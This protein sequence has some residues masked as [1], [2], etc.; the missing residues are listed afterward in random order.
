MKH[1]RGFIL[2]FGLMCI[3]FLPFTTWAQTNDTLYIK[4][5]QKIAKGQE[6]KIN[7]G[8]Q[9]S[10]AS[11]AALWVEG[12]L[13]VTGDSKAPVI[14]T[15]ENPEEPG[16]GIIING[17]DPNARI[18]IHNA[19]FNSLLRPLSFEPFWN[20]KT[21]SLENLNVKNS[22]FNEA[23]IFVAAPLVNLNKAAIQFELSN[24][25]FFHNNAGII[26]E[27]AGSSGIV[28]NLDNLVFQ[29]NKLVG[30]DNSLGIL[31]INIAN[32]YNPKNLNIG[33]LVFINNTANNKTLGLSL[34]GSQEAI[35]AEGI[36]S[37]NN[38]RPVFD[39]QQDARLPLLEA[40][41]KD[42]S[43]YPLPLCYTEN[44]NH[45]KGRIALI[46]KK[47]CKI[48]KVVD[49]NYVTIPATYSVLA[50]SILINY[51]EGVAAYVLL[52]NGMEEKLPAIPL[53]DTTSLTP[54]KP[55]PPIVLQDT[56]INP[57][58]PWEKTYE[59]G[60]MGGLAFYVGDIKHRFGIPGVYDWSSTAFV[61]YNKSPKVSYRFGFSRTN[62][63]M[64]NPTAALMFFRSA[65]TY[66]LKNGNYFLIPSFENNFK[67]KMYNLDFDLIYYFLDKHDNSK[68]LNNTKKGEWIPAIGTGASLSYF[69]PY[70]MVVYSRNRD[71]AEFM[72][73]RPLGLEGQ[74]FLS[75]KRD[76][77]PI[78]INLNI[79][80]QLCYA[81]K[82]WRFRYE[83]KAI[84]S[85]SDYLDD[86][87]QGYAYGGNYEEWKK[88]VGNV[89]LPV[90][91]HTGKQITLEQAFP[92][93]T[94]EIKRTTNL[95]PDMYFPQHIGVSYVLGK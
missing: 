85:F 64:H 38:L 73:L 75:N 33:N 53:E 83:V 10:F 58:Q 22:V 36:Y 65:D 44:I 5:I 12:S 8:T 43:T 62:I 70:R 23:V 86:F 67:T 84:M 17:N 57:T 42:A 18:V 74:N 13:F 24:S 35:S 48:T 82:N 21:V 56:L 9:V 25:Q 79:S 27:N 54:E 30:N 46:G 93:Y 1:L 90:D 51:Q 60:L 80:F 2:Q 11:G 78:T 61:Q 19:S 16:T 77:I 45:T 92:N 87:G 31:N 71:S 72:K 7:A 95:L 47:L 20:R 88:N 29:N 81:Y 40:P 14:F 50:D 6:L 76:Y 49:S 69:E 94:S 63:G 28:Y 34:G 37:T 32:P 52:E 26:I 3:G 89:D 91:K 15:S 41:I 4:G 39:N 59:V 68:S 66:G 55:K